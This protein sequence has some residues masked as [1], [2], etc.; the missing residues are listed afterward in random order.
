VVG[1]ASS[2]SFE[3]RTRA[4]KCVCEKEEV[5]REIQRFLCCPRFLLRTCHGKHSRKYQRSEISRRSLATLDF[6]SK[7]AKEVISRLDFAFLD[8]NHAECE[9]L[10]KRNGFL[11]LFIAFYVYHNGL[12]FAI[13]GDNQGNALFRY[14]LQE[15]LG[16]GF[17]V[18][19]WSDL[20][21]YFH[22]LLPCFTKSDS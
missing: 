21:R 22:S 9:H 5:G 17:Q 4:E 16:M 7:P 13:L 3:S 14:V 6:L 15:L 10:E 20:V 8:L 19:D 2:W 11:R 12:G 1:G 18:T